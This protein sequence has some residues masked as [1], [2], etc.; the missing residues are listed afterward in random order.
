M[1]IDVYDTYVLTNDN[2]RMHFDVLVEQGTNPDNAK[3]YAQQW[4]AT[5]GIKVN[6]IRQ[7]N[8]QF[9]RTEDANLEVENTIANQ[10][11]AIHQL[12]GCPQPNI[13]VQ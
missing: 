13:L 6:Q 1:K 3:F 8:S 10:C 12:E 9:C 7:T 5:L 4:L 2:T 11:Y